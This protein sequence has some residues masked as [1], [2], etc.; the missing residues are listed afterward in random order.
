MRHCFCERVKQMREM[1]SLACLL[2]LALS[3]IGLSAQGFGICCVEVGET[4]STTITFSQPPATGFSHY[5]IM[6][7][8]NTLQDYQSVA[9]ITDITQTI[10]SFPL[11]EAATQS[12]RC[13]VRAVYSSGNNLQDDISTIFLGFEQNQ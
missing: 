3:A 12:V 8:D 13:R 10:Y 9:T 4:T 1:K 7:F 2:A 5:D 11:A 6:T